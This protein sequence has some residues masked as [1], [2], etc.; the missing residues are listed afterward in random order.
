MAFITGTA[1]AESSQTIKVWAPHSSFKATI[2][3]VEV[4][5]L[6]FAH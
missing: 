4:F 2:S 5:K 3:E 1:A 6:A